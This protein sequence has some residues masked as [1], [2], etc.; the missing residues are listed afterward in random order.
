VTRDE[1]RDWW[2]RWPDANIGVLIVDGL[3]VLD[4]DPR[5]G[6]RDTVAELGIRAAQTVTSITGGGGEHWYFRDNRTM[7][8]QTLGPGLEVLAE[9]KIAVLPPS[10]HV[11]G[12][13]YQWELGFGPDEMSLAPVPDWLLDLS[14]GAD[15]KVDSKRVCKGGREWDSGTP[16]PFSL[17]ERLTRELL[18]LGGELQRD[19]R[20]LVRCPFPG[21][22]ET[23]PSF[24]YSP[25]TGRWWCF[26]AGHPGR[27]A[28]QV[29]VGG[30]AYKLEHTLKEAISREILISVINHLFAG[31]DYQNEHKT[32]SLEQVE[33]VYQTMILRLDSRVRNKGD[34]ASKEI[35]TMK[36]VAGSLKTALEGFS[37]DRRPGGIRIP[38]LK[39]GVQ[40]YV[41]VFPQGCGNPLCPIH[42]L[43]K[44]E[45]N[46]RP[47]RNRLSKLQRPALVLFRSSE[48]DPRQVAATLRKLERRKRYPLK[49]RGCYK[50]ILPYRPGV[51][52]AILADLADGVVDVD[53]LKALWGEDVA[54]VIIPRQKL[55]ELMR[56]LIRQVDFPEAY[57]GDEDYWLSWLLQTRRLQCARPTGCVRRQAGEA[58]ERKPNLCPHGNVYGKPM[59]MLTPDQVEEGLSRGYLQETPYGLI[60]I[61]ETPRNLWLEPSGLHKWKERTIKRRREREA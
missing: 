54:L 7:R 1:V 36:A 27:K 19:G 15:S 59:G 44:A 56:E 26:G 41:H 50:I 49:D 21:H 17:R 60:E 31:S 23:D 20:I 14:L 8:S 28:G 46:L 2:H 33:A 61:R 43:A 57:S 52:V 51:Q 13:R 24:Y 42:S 37:T 25:I 16:A 18:S 55:P 32:M 9:G 39:D 53:R 5:N 40:Q 38:C 48:S 6:G 3:V 10:L 11:T 45:E 34:T 12:Q 47:K 4:I 35:E 22:Q 30:S 29:S 58:E